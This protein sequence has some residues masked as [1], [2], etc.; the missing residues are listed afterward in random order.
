MKDFWLYLIL[1]ILALSF[2]YIAITFP[3]Y[4]KQIRSANKRIAAESRIL[5]TKLGNLEYAVRGK[6]K[7]ILLIHGAG[8]GYDQGLW[9]GEICLDDDCQFI[10]PSKFGYLN[11]SLPINISMKIQAEQYKILLDALNVEKVTI[12]A[13]SAGG[14]SAMQFANDYHERV[15]KLILL[16]AVSM[17]S[18]SNDKNLFFIKFI[19]QIQKSDYAYWLFTRLFETQILSLM[20]IPYDDYKNFTVEQKNL[21]KRMLELM[22]PMSL[23]HDGTIAD[24][25]MIKDFVIP[26]NIA[27]PTLIIHSKNDGLVSY[28]HAEYANKSIQ[29]SR[30]I[31]YKNGGHGALSELENARKEI[32]DFLNVQ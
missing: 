13:V 29:G 21:A 17:P 2:I 19:H 32:K 27:I 11:S 3:V 26:K 10:A 18:N 1:A 24:G 25:L 30:I 22:H 6:G 16:S 4:Q 12:I 15:D 9:L 5:K 7:P 8:G 14:P 23:R 31:L 20:G 28:S